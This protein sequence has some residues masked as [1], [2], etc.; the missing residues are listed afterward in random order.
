M[1]GRT[2]SDRRNVDV[3]RREK[4]GFICSGVHLRNLARCCAAHDPVCSSPLEDHMAIKWPA[5]RRDAVDRV[6]RTYPKES[7]QCE[8]AAKEIMPFAK[9]QD[10]NAVKWKIAPKRGYGFRCLAPR[11]SVGDDPWFY[12]VFVETEQH[13]VDSLAGVDGTA[14]DEYLD[15]HFEHSDCIQQYRIG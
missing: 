6:L 14:A 11:V 4:I 13:G 10:P 1:V 3:A 12:H 5:R 15:V 8:E 2:A 7:R 9:E